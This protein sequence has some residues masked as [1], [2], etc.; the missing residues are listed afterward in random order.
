MESKNKEFLELLSSVLKNQT[1]DVTLTNGKVEKFRPLSTAQLKN[2]IKTIVDTSVTQI[3]FNSAVTS[4]MRECYAGSDLKAVDG[5]NVID[6]VCFLIETRIQSVSPTITIGAN[7]IS[8]QEVKTKLLSA[9]EANKQ[10]LADHD[11]VSEGVTLTI[12]VPTIKTE[13]QVDEEIYKNLTLNVEDQ[14]QVRKMLGEAFVIELT[15]TVKKITI[16]DKELD[17]ASLFFKERQKVVEELPASV[18][19]EVINYVESYK[20]VINTSITGNEWDLTLDG[21]LFSIQ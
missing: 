10:I 3:Q 6:K 4:V 21:S 14:E 19:Q 7:K 9:I 15:K 2:L 16:G 8:L 5:F 17:L 20:K 11:I 18:I 12:G 13:H 1:F